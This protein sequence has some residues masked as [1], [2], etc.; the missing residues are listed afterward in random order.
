MLCS[1]TQLFY[2]SQT[3]FRYLGVFFF[4]LA[5]GQKSTFNPSSRPRQAEELPDPRPYPA[6]R[7]AWQPCLP[8]TAPAAGRGLPVPLPPPQNGSCKGE[9]GFR[10]LP[11]AHLGQP[12]EKTGPFSLSNPCRAAD[13][14]PPS[15]M[16]MPLH[17]GGVPRGTSLLPPRG[18]L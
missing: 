9:L 12:Q 16:Q 15:H 5:A 1:G 10:P 17:N 8:A 14:P 2:P 7:H 3:A 4:P 13:K 11:A 6:A 18:M